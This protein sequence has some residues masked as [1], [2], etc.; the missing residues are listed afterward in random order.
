MPALSHG[1]EAG[2]AVFLKGR[3]YENSELYSATIVGILGI[4]QKCSAIEKQDKGVL[5]IQTFS[6][7]PLRRAGHMPGVT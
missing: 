1:Y 7:G 3:F 5:L 4:K 2:V 6:Y